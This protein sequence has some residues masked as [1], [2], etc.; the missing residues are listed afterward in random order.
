MTSNLGSAE[1]SNIISPGMGFV[2]AAPAADSRL[3]DKIAR[4]GVDA[5]RKKFTPEFL[6]RI[7]KAVVFKPLGDEQLRKILDLELG[8]VQQR[9]FA[10]AQGVQFVFQLTD[11]AKS[12]LLREGTDMKYGARHLKRAV[13]RHLVYPLSNLIATEQVHAG[14]MLRVDLDSG[15]DK[16]IFCKEAEGLPIYA[17]ASQVYPESVPPAGTAAVAVKEQQAGHRRAS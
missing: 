5:A 16:L 6:N 10:S 1:M 14:D 2:E 13:E 11:E 12:Y 3:W 8:Y 9:I 17:M 4:A 7:D 15:I